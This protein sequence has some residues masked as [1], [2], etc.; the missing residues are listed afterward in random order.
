MRNV[1]TYAILMIIISGCSSIEK[2]VGLGV[3]SESVST[4][5]DAV[6]VK[7]SDSRNYNDGPNRPTTMF[8]AKWS[9]NNP[10]DIILYMVF[11]SSI[12][13]GDAYE[14]FNGMK[15]NIGGDMRSFDVARR[16]ALSSGN[17]NDVTNTIYTRSS[18]PVIIPMSYLERMLN[19]ESVKIRISM[20]DTYEDIIFDV[21][22]DSYGNTYS[23]ANITKF[24]QKIKS[25]M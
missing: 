19:A 16:T 24:I 8:S 7:L 3:V 22:K 25:K 17:Y 11:R 23:K 6:I 12:S 10:D 21:G 1:L 4:F 9:S 18:A 14:T 20:I 2:M 15:V 13:N 5:D